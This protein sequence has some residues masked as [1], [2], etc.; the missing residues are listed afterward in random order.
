MIYPVDCAIHLMNN[1][2]QT[3][4][5]CHK[6]YYEWSDVFK[7]QKSNSF[8]ATENIKIVSFGHVQLIIIKIAHFYVSQ[9][10]TLE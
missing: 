4:K 1:C 7:A 10:Q 2:G 3:I 8:S 5:Y 6:V 9:C